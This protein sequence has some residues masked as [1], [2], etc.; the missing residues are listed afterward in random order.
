MAKPM[1]FFGFVQTFLSVLVLPFGFLIWGLSAIPGIW[2]FQEVS[3]ISDPLTRL[4]AQGVAIGIGLLAWCV[5][6]LL[7]LGIFGLIL[8]WGRSLSSQ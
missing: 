1:K 4:F 8:L 5:V 2:I 6:D 7:I 3:D